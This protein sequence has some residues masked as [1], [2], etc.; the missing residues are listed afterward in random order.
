MDKTISRRYNLIDFIRGIAVINMMLYHLLWD[1]N[2][3]FKAVRLEWYRGIYGFIWQQC[4]CWVFILISGYC[5]NFS[6]HY[7]K[8][9][10]TVLACG[11][12]ISIATAVFTPESRITFGILTF[13]GTAMLLVGILKKYL[14][15][16]PP[17]AGFLSSFFIFLVCYDIP[18]GKLG[19][20]VF[21]LRLPQSLYTSLAGTFFGFMKHDF[22]SSDYYPF[23]PWIFLFIAGF[24]LFEL[25]GGV[26]PEKYDLFFAPIN[27]TG[28]YTLPVYMLHQPV[29]Y[30]ILMLF[31]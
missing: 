27:L 11:M 19:F 3:A 6:R 9:A 23:L 20:S 14:S 29:I 8:R 4:I 17:A 21:A 13:M 18:K 5:I 15:K 10:L 31:M 30:G 12:L 25:S 22:Y 28:R 16:L 24:Y 26:T 2:Y 7:V 1:L